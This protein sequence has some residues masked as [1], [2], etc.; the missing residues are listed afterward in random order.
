MGYKLRRLWIVGAAFQPRIVL[1]PAPASDPDPGFAGVTGW[2]LF[3]K[4]SS[5]QSEE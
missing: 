4:Q 1:T 3:T 5:I 2:G